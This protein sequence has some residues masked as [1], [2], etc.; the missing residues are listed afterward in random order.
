MVFNKVW[1]GYTKYLHSLV[2]NRGRTVLCPVFGTFIP[3][4]TYQQAM[5]AIVDNDSTV[6]GDTQK[7]TRENLEKLESTN[8]CYAPARELLENLGLSFKDDGVA[9]IDPYQSMIQSPP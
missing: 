8:V 9:N 2:L 7:M 5:L 4:A 6:H 3:G 1:S